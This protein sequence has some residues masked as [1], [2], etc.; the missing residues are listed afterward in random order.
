[1]DIDEAGLQRKLKLNELEEIRN[2][3]YDSA[4]IY[5][6]NAK[7]FHDRM[8]KKKDFVVGQKVLLFHS[9]LKLFP[10]KLRS[11]WLGPFVITHI[12]PSGAIRIKGIKID[13]EFTV[14][15]HR[16]KPY[17]ENFVEPNVEETS[18]IEPK[19]SEFLEIV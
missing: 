2:E 16:L 1:M 14:N 5:K 6:D 3:A 8:I 7:T 10:G 13:K 9:R 19:A 12:F 17:Y 11:R 4:M 15:G 18:L